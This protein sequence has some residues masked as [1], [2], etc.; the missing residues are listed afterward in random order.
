M[1]LLGLG[2]PQIVNA[3]G[4]FMAVTPFGNIDTGVSGL[5]A[6]GKQLA[7]EDAKKISALE[8]KALAG[9][10]KL[11]TFGELNKDLGSK[12]FE[13]L[14]QNPI[15]GK[16]EI[17]WFEK[18]GTK[19]QQEMIGRVKT[20]MGKIIAD[21]AGD[22]KGQFRIGEQALLNE[23]KPGVGDSLSVMKGKSEALTYLTTMMTKR[24][25]LEADLMRDF[26]M[27]A[28]KARIAVNKEI[29]PESIKKE[30]H[31]ILHPASSPTITIEEAKAELERRKAS[32]G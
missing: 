31:T 29:D 18:F 21:A 23:T 15:L 10:Q 12:E 2:H 25:E 5:S 28:L 22:F 16:H 3:N 14:R 11:D 6:R 26:N 9:Y 20:N 4:K 17:G 7:V 32:R 24:A 8:D 1:Q 27:S 30:V 19:E 13:A